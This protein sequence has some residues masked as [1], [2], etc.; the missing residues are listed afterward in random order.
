MLTHKRPR[1]WH[2]IFFLDSFWFNNIW[3]I[4][5]RCWIKQH[6]VT[7]F[8]WR[9]YA[10]MLQV[11][12]AVSLK[13]FFYMSIPRKWDN[14]P[15]IAFIIFISFKGVAQPQEVFGMFLAR[16]DVGNSNSTCFYLYNARFRFR[17]IIQNVFMVVRFRE[18]KLWQVARVD[19][20]RLFNH[21]IIFP[22]PYIL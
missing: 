13:H 2:V 12:L 16:P 10:Y 8:L 14:H 19:C 18:P 20:H 9:T 7:L 17:G 1:P 6:L 21:G 15:P 3:M 11:R 5:S 22:E 4:D